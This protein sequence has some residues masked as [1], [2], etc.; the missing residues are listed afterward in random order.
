M[1]Q[2]LRITGAL[3]L[4]LTL[5]LPMSRCST[6]P[7]PHVIAQIFHAPQ[8]PLLRDNYLLSG[9]NWNL[10][11]R[12]GWDSPYLILLAFLWPFATLQLSYNP[13][14]RA[15]HQWAHGLEVFTLIYAGLDIYYVGYFLGGFGQILAGFYTGA[16]GVALCA[17]VWLI[18]IGPIIARSAA[19]IIFPLLKKRRRS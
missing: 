14:R 4:A 2:K 6:P 16:A 17:L 1:L 11:R 19:R 5:C 18:E 9:A 3:L 15:W 12:P 10:H 7:Q 13:A 8:K